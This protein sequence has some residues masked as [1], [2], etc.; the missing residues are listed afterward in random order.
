MVIRADTIKE[1]KT[2]KYLLFF[3]KNGFKMV[4]FFL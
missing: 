1:G 4:S 3:F 2:Y